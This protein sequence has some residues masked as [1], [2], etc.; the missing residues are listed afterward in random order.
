MCLKGWRIDNTLNF[1]YHHL[2]NVQKSVV[3]GGVWVLIIVSRSL[4]LEAA[5][6]VL[7]EVSL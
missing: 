6:H 7:P 2:I 1:A 5:T 4:Q 3:R